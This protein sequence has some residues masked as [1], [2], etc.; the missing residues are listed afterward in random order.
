MDRIILLV[1][2]LKLVVCMKFEFA[3]RLVVVPCMSLLQVSFF[4]S[5]LYYSY[6]VALLDL[7]GIGNY[8]CVLLTTLG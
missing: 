3:C 5:L 7:L 2:L 4:A 6:L 1:G 8:I